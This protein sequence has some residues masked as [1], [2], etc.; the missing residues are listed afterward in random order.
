M[1]VCGGWGGGGS[2]EEPECDLLTLIEPELTQQ[3]LV[4]VALQLA[5]VKQNLLRWHS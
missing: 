1:S 4:L 2:V 5:L 3:P